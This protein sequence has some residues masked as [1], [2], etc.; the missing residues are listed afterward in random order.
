[1][2]LNNHCSWTSQAEPYPQSTSQ[3]DCDI[4]QQLRDSA[5]KNDF[6]ENSQGSQDNISQP[7]E[8]PEPDPQEPSVH[9]GSSISVLSHDRKSKDFSSHT[10]DPSNLR[11]IMHQSKIAVETKLLPSS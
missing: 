2:Q 1:M 9:V 10:A 11:P 6:L 7:P 5:P 4:L 3:T 8:T